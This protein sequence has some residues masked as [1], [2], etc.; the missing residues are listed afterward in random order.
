MPAVDRGSTPNGEFLAGRL[1]ETA[2]PLGL[3]LSAQVHTYLHRASFGVQVDW[4]GDPSGE[5]VFC[6]VADST[7]AVMLREPRN[8][9]VTIEQ[10]VTY[11]IERVRGSSPADAMSLAKP[12]RRRWR[13]R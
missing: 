3:Q 8:A 7:D 4:P 10:A 6:E 2:R 1:R 13:R 5:G 9:E 11:V 12:P